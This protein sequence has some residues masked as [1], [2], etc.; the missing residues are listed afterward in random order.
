MH[1]WSGFGCNIL[2]ILVKR[3]SVLKIFLNTFIYSF[4]YN[5]VGAITTCWDPSLQLQA[6]RVQ[7]DAS[8]ANDA[9]QT[10]KG[11]IRSYQIGWVC[12][13]TSVSRQGLLY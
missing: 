6:V 11:H 13:S 4:K 10:V 2:V 12:L 1:R 3:G 7:T 8:D 9:E 5:E